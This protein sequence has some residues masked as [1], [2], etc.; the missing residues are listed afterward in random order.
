[1][2]MEFNATKL[3]HAHEIF[4]DTGNNIAPYSLWII[5]EIRSSWQWWIELHPLQSSVT[6]VLLET[7]EVT[8]DRSG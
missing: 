4:K 2:G 7:A 8:K 5:S 1:M 6:L 3:L